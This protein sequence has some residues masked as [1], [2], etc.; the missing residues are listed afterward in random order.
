MLKLVIR[1]AIPLSLAVALTAC[2]VGRFVT[3]VSPNGA[4]SLA[5]EKCI[6]KEFNGG[7]ATLGAKYFWDQE[8]SSTTLNNVV[9]K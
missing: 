2:N 1:F 6:T 5:V 4:G 8:C 3:N 9:E 7:I